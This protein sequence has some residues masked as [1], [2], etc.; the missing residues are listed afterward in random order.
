MTGPEEARPHD[1][2]LAAGYEAELKEADRRFAAEVATADPAARGQVWAGWFTDDGRQLVP[3]RVVEGTRSIA[4]MMG[5]IFPQPGT[6]LTWEP[7]LAEAAPS[8]DMGWTS[9]R[10]ESRRSGPE[11]ESVEHGRYLTIWRRQAD[12]SWKVALDT[13]VP[14]VQD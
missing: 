11:G 13:G 2:G 9:G 7:D 4:E 12:G 1:P 8:G 6:Q 5:P 14:D 10:Y 3:G